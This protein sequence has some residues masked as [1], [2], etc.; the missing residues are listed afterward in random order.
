MTRLA[1]LL[2]MLELCACSGP[3]PTP[4]LDALARALVCNVP[5]AAFDLNGQN[6]GQAHVQ[7]TRTETV[8]GVSV[9]EPPLTPRFTRGDDSLHVTLDGSNAQPGDYDVSAVSGGGKWTITH[10][11][12]LL[13][14]PS[15]TTETPTGL[16]N[17]QSAQTL[18]VDGDGFFVINGQAPTVSIRDA[19]G[20]EKLVVAGTPAECVQAIDSVI[21]GVQLCNQLSLELPTAQLDPGVYAAVVTD[22]APLGC[23]STEMRPFFVEA[24]PTI[25]TTT[26]SA[27]LCQGGGEIQIL[28]DGF[29]AGATVALGG[30]APASTTVVGAGEISASFPF[31]PLLIS[32]Q[33]LSLVV[34]NPDGC[35]ASAAQAVT[36]LPGPVLLAVDPP[37]VYAA[38]RTPLVLHLSSATTPPA[39]TITSQSTGVPVTLTAALDPAHATRVVAELP[40][41][42]PAGLYDLG[43]SDGSSCS[44]TLTGAVRVT[45][46]DKLLLRSVRPA[47]GDRSATQRIA[48]TA[49]PSSA[50]AIAAGARVFLAREDG[51]GTAVVPL[52]AQLE[53]G[54]LHAV[55]PAG[56]AAGGYDVVV[57]N[58][59]GTVGVLDGAASFGS[60][61]AIDGA[62]P[63]VT[64][65]APEA[66][67]PGCSGCT[68]TLDGVGFGAAPTV[69]ATCYAAGSAAPLGSAPSFPL[70][71]SPSPTPNPSEIFVD[72]T[73]LAAMPHGTHCSLYVINNDGAIRPI[74]EADRQV[75][76][77]VGLSPVDASD[78][79]FELA[80]SL[81]T[82][83]RA[84]AVVVAAAEPGGHFLYAL[85]G[86]GGTV[87]ST[88][89]DGEWAPIGLAG[90]GPFATLP[91]SPLP[92]GTTLAGAV[93][94]GRWIFLVGG[95][96]GHSSLSSVTRGEVLDP[97]EAPLFDDLG[98]A[99]DFGGSGLSAGTYY[100]RV[101]AR[102]DL[103]DALNPNGE[104]LA[105][106]PVVITLPALAQSRD[107]LLDWSAGA[108]SGRT[109]AGWR[110]YRGAAPDALDAYLDLPLATTSFTD[111]NTQI[112]VSGAPLA[113]GAL[114]RFSSSGVPQLVTPRAGAAV[115]AVPDA[116]P[117]RYFLYSGFGWDSTGVTP[118]PVSYEVLQVDVG[119]SGVTFGSATQ[120]TQVPFGS[121]GRWLTGAFA[122]TPERDSRFAD[123]F[124]YFGQGTSNLTL[125][126]ISSSDNIAELD[127]GQISTGGALVSLGTLP[128]ATIEYGY[129]AL[130]GGDALVMLGGATATAQSSS[131]PWRA[132]FGAM[133]PASDGWNT[134]AP[135]LPQGHFLP[136]AA[137]DGPYIFV[138]GGS[139]ASLGL[140]SASTE[141]SL[142]LY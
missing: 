119:A 4:E 7:I 22:P 134:T 112:T 128:A 78:M 77:A 82:A 120:F 10:G 125:G 5:G 55:V 139:I 86:D 3:G 117:G 67:E 15:V 13:P 18:T 72:G 88:R 34:A 126:N 51:G 30:G 106:P 102:F 135:L 114:G 59:D 95:Y 107:A 48:I 60:Y 130:G 58:P 140:G 32:G 89:S 49:D 122:A 14:P 27:S 71:A 84:P 90:L 91:G 40:P 79:T 6:L 96:D 28:G 1:P 66:L 56:L 16:C 76:V 85:G 94:A 121:A 46:D 31:S 9:D 113:L 63:L 131:T 73:L 2:M 99:L 111:D 50:V 37:I 129:A 36:I 98:V 101:S 100:Y 138:V 62:P 11:L 24:P 53:A 17:A 132:P 74:G 124:V 12:A 83:R 97:M 70:A 57:V 116:T 20:I 41:G 52:D 35:R 42:L 75:S 26:S 61:Q 69:G 105:S 43:Y 44:T 108:T 33:Q 45:T 115:T 8:V 118:L 141:V 127:G 93:A 103:G 80:P 110:L 68:V 23:S 29:A 25:D 92:G 47:F 142:G 21:D 123:R 137:S 54:A 65:V 133:T 104:S 19:Q 136:G 64:R 109:I 81:S 87:T 38:Y 39:V